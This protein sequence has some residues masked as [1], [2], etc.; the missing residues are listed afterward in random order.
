MNSMRIAE[1]TVDLRELKAEARRLLPRG[2]PIRRALDG[3]LDSL[4]VVE[5][6]A[7]L[8]VYAR[9]LL[10]AREGSRRG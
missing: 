5:G 3:E 10:A 4:P 6:R 1:A 9:L 7:V 8:R 2:H